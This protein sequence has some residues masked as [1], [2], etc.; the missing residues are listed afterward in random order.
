M[1]FD[2]LPEPVADNIQQYI[3][4]LNRCKKDRWTFNKIMIDNHTDI[5]KKCRLEHQNYLSNIQSMIK[6][7][8]HNLH[9]DRSMKYRNVPTEI[10]SK[11][12]QLQMCQCSIDYEKMF[13][14]TYVPTCNQCTTKWET[15]NLKITIIVNEWNINKLQNRMCDLETKVSSIDDR[16][17]DYRYT[18]SP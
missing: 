9:V 5:C 8:S 1:E 4:Y 14:G 2:K 18:P 3:N 17:E 12:E 7:Y 6:N 15:T 11:I 10:Q 13:N 16:V